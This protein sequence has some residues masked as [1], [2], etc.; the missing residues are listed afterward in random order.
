MKKFIALILTIALLCALTAPVF[1]TGGDENDPAV[2]KSYLEQVWLSDFL[3]TVKVDYTDAYN[4]SL[5]ALA[6]SVAEKNLQ[7]QQKAV[8]QRGLGHTTF[9]QGDVIV[10]AAGCKIQLYSGTIAS[11]SGLVDVT[12]GQAAQG[13][14][15]KETL[16]M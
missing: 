13:N 9:K 3:K 5:S 11:A 10:L 2:T 6:E 7:K 15:Q 16:Y 14:L 1:A 12:H 4:K 8:M